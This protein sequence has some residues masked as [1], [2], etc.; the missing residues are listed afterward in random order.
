MDL[1][2]LILKNGQF[3]QI[4]GTDRL[5]CP[6]LLINGS[7]TVKR[8]PVNANYVIQSTDYYIGVTSTAAPRTMTLPSAVAVGVGWQVAIKDES[9]GAAANSITISPVLAQTIDGAANIVIA[10]NDGS[11]LLM[12][13]GANW[14]VLY[15]YAGLGGGFVQS[16][17]SKVLVDTTYAG[18]GFSTLLSVTLNCEANDFLLIRAHAHVSMD[19]ANRYGYFRLLVDGNPISAGGGFRYNNLPAISA[20]LNG[21]E[22][23]L[24]TAAHTVELQWRVFVAGWTV[25]CRPVLVPDAESASLV[26]EEVRL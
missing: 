16:G 18:A 12:S 8:T 1:K 22:Q 4:P 11:V 9:G 7:L 5:A 14:V 6:D 21:R 13:D 23:V 10:A 24:T 26:V 17:R 20:C 15:Q 19:A 25:R 2:P 3:S